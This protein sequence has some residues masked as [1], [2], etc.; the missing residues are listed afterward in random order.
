VEDNIKLGLEGR[1]W[2][3]GPVQD[4]DKWRPFVNT[5]V[6]LWVLLNTGCLLT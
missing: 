2:E 3:I 6:N 1:G 5:A 4:R